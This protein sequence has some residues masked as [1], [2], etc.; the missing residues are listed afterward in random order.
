MEVSLVI[1][2]VGC[3]SSACPSPS[4]NL[5]QI[6][7]VG[8]YQSQGVIGNTLNTFENFSFVVPSD[9]SGQAS[10]QVQHG[11]LTTLP[12]SLF[13]SFLTG[14]FIH[15]ATKGPVAIPGVEYTS[16]AVQVGTAPS[17]YNI[18]PSADSSKCVGILGGVYADGTAV[19]M[20][21]HYCS[22]NLLHLN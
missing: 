22:S 12:V 9:I 13:T 19:D 20:Y 11:F 4:A 16:V 8:I 17:A 3:G 18:H 15:S 7:F 21:V 6:L 14:L 5:G 2:I 10:I 1:G